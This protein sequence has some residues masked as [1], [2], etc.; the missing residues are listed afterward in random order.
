MR[1]MPSRS[2]SKLGLE[3]VNDHQQMVPSRR[4]FKFDLMPVIEYRDPSVSEP[5]F[6]ASSGNHLLARMVPLHLDFN[7][8]L[9]FDSTR[10][11]VQD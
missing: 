3:S 11:I 4:Y 1:S 10:A 9:T 2:M 8:S 5:T 7:S 6:I